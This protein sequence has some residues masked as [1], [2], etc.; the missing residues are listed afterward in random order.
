[1]GVKPEACV[2]IEDSPFGVQAARSA[3]MKVLGYCA[4]T[5]EASLA[6]WGAITFKH[7][8]QLPSLIEQI[9]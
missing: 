3:G 5:P 9:G 7:M 2:V 6:Q 1:M 8:H 4:M